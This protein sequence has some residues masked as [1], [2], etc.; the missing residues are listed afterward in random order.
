MISRQF[1][2]VL[3]WE[4]KAR[5]NPL[6]AVMSVPDFEQADADPSH[7]SREQIDLFFQKGR[8]LFEVYLA[9]ILRRAG[10]EPSRT[11]VFEYGSGMGRIL[12]AVHEAGYDAAGVD[13]SPTM[14]QYSRRLVPE[15][16]DLHLVGSDGRVPLPDASADLVYSYAVLQ[17]ISKKSLVRRAVDEMCRVLKPGGYLRLQFQPGSMPFGSAPKESMRAFNFEDRSLVLRWVKLQRRWQ[18]PSWIPRL[19]V[20][21]L[22]RHSH[23]A[24]VPLGWRTM[25]RYLAAG[26][27]RLV[28]L[29]R[30]PVADWNSVWILGRKDLWR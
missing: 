29:E 14:L 25:R 11:R 30:D 10:L 27:V 18:L 19:P 20:A 13:I 17:H 23:W 9:P 8:L 12:R 24:G 3:T 21:L 26:G 16:T 1:T 22:R 4:E 6:W 28:S 7:W 15:V 5:L 2:D